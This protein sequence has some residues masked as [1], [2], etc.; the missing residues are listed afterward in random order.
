MLTRMHMGARGGQQITKKFETMLNDSAS[1]P[2]NMRA[3]LGAIRD[4]ATNVQKGNVPPEIG[5]SEGTPQAGVPTQATGATA[6]TPGDLDSLL[7]KH[8]Y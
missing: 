7:K 4:Y 1:S 6:G 2:E 5:G 3:A 8:G